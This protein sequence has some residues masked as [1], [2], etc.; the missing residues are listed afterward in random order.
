MLRFGLGIAAAAFALDRLS[1]W[2]LIDL[3]DGPARG[4]EVAPF[5][6]LVL[7]WNRGVAFGLLRVESALT[8]WLLSAVALVIVAGLVFWLHRAE[9]RRLATALGLVIGGALGNVFDRLAFGAVA[10]FFDF[11]L[12]A[13][14][15][16]AFNLADT[17]IVVGVAM[18]LLDGLF[19]GRESPKK[20]P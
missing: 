7:T 5:F 6:N 20:E 4:I 19:G 11:F 1:K 10:D 2:L 9:E 3:W 12:G 8:P 17:T 13:Y 15:W 16:P 18:L 14:H